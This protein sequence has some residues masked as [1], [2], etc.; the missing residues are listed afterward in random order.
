MPDVK[1]TRF[2]H[3]VG[4][5]LDAVVGLFEVSVG[6]AQE[7]RL[8]GMTGQAIQALKDTGVL[9]HPR[10]MVRAVVDA[11]RYSIELEPTQTAKETVGVLTSVG[12][13]ALAAQRAQHGPTSEEDL[14]PLLVDGWDKVR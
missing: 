12:W 14:E 10:E 2:N 3:L 9:W 4:T 6:G 11:V 7:H 13:V 8:M 1:I 5:N